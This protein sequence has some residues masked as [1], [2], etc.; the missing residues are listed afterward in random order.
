[1]PIRHA[2]ILGIVQG[3]TEFFP[4]SSSAHLEITRAAFGWQQLDGD[5]ETFFD[6]AVHLG[7]L[8]GAIIYLRA[9]I[10]RYAIA[11]LAPLRHQPLNQEG[12]IGWFLTLSAVPAGL[13]GVFFASRINN[14][15]N[16]AVIALALIVFGLL[17]AF[18]DGRQ[19]SRGPGNFRLADSLLIGLGQ[20]L[21]LQPGVSR[22]GATLSVARFLGFERDAAARLVFLMSLPVIAGAGVFAFLGLLGSEIP[23]SF[24]AVFVSGATAAAIT[25]FF[26]VWVTMRLIRARSFMVFVWYRVVLGLAILGL[27]AAGWL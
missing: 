5:L 22:S 18:A 19:A 14:A 15:D 23:R 11:A 4:V 8:L 27:L 17:L 21:A 13:V 24:W 10:V 2:I 7:T 25:G 26:A 9:D 12:R 6:V 1:M 16:L 20:A 3:L